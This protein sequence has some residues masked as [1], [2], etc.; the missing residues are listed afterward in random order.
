MAWLILFFAA[1]CEIGWAAG[2]KATNGFSRPLPTVLVIICMI[3]S[4][5]LLGLATKQLPIGTAYAVWTG[6]GA[7]GVAVIGIVVWGE[8]AAPAR[9][10][11]MGMIAAGVVGLK[12]FSGD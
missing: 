11:C 7:L 3:A 8:S 10:I 2:L 9:L 4:M 1:L 6:I 12:L 5:L